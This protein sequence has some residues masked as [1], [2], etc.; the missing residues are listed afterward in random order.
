MTQKLATKCPHCERS[1]KID[2]NKVGQVVRCPACRERFTVSSI[3]FSEQQGSASPSLAALETTDQASSDSTTSASNVIGS[4]EPT[5]GK[6][7]RFELKSALGQGAFGTVYRAYDPVL[8]RQL[9]LK[10]PKFATSEKKKIRR[11]IREA[12][13][14]ASLHHPNIVAVFESGQANGQ[15]YIAS[16]FVDGTPMSAIIADERPDFRRSAEWILALAEGLAYAHEF[17]I[18]H[19]DI[20]PD[21]IMVGKSGHPQLMDF[22]LAKR[23]DE[24]SSMTAD[25]GVVGTP[26]YMPPEQ[27]RGDLES[28]GPHS[29]QYSLGVVLYE[30]L[31]GQRPFSGPPHSVI[32]QITTEN[33]PEPRQLD[34]E[35]PVDLAA[36]CSKAMEKNPEQRYTDMTGMAQDLERWLTGLETTARPIGRLEKTRRW[37]HR[38]RPFAASLAAVVVLLVVWLLGATGA[39]V[40]FRQ[41]EKYQSQLASENLELADKN[42]QLADES[43]AALVDAERARNN[44]EKRL[45]EQ[46]VSRGRGLCE[47]GDQGLGLH[48]LARALASVPAGERDMELAIR[49]DLGAFS[50]SI[51]RLTRMIPLGNE[52]TSVDISQ[53]GK[54]IAAV[55]GGYHMYEGQGKLFLIDAATGEV[56]GP[57]QELGGAGW[58]VSF[59]SDEDIVVVGTSTF[60]E[61][62]VSL[63]NRKTN[64]FEQQKLQLRSM[65]EGIDVHPTRRL[66]AVTTLNW[67]FQIWDWSTGKKIAAKVKKPP[68]NGVAFSPDGDYLA[69]SSLGDEGSIGRIA[70]WDVNRQQFSNLQI[71]TSPGAKAL[72]YSADGAFLMATTTNRG[73]AVFDVNSQY[74]DVDYFPLNVNPMDLSTDR[75]GE[76]TAISGRDGT[77][78]I[79]D[80]DSEELVGQSLHH[81]GQVHAVCFSPTGEQL[82]TAAEDGYVRIWETARRPPPPQSR[83]PGGGVYR[84]S[85]SPNDEI[86]LA[87]AK[88]NVTNVLSA[89]TLNVQNTLMKSRG[90]LCVKAVSDQY[91]ISDSLDKGIVELWDLKGGY[92]IS[93]ELKLELTVSSLDCAPNGCHIAIGTGQTDLSAGEIV[94]WDVQ[95]ASQVH[96]PLQLESPPLSVCY[97]PSGNLIAAGTTGG[98]V[99]C[100]DAETGEQLYEPIRHQGWVDEVDFTIDGALL[101]TGC[102]DGIV[103]LIDVSTGELT[104]KPLDIGAKINALRCAPDGRTIAVGTA[105]G[106]VRL[107]DIATRRQIGRTV[108][109]AS[110]VVTIDFTGQDNR[111]VTGRSNGIVRTWPLPNYDQRSTDSLLPE[112]EAATGIR[113]SSSGEREFL[114][115]T[116][117]DTI[118]EA[119]SQRPDETR[120]SV[121]IWLPEERNVIDEQLARRLEQSKRWQSTL[122]AVAED[123]LI[124]QANKQT[125]ALESKAANLLQKEDF[126]QA[127]QVFEELAKFPGYTP[128]AAVLYPLY[129]RT[130]QWE[131]ALNTG[132]KRP[133]GLHP[134]ERAFLLYELGQFDEYREVRKQLLATTDQ[135]AH[136]WSNAGYLY[137]ALLM[138]V[139]PELHP[140]IR[141]LAE[142]CATRPERWEKMMVGKAMYRLGEFANWHKNLP[143]DSPL[144]VGQEL[145]L[146]L[147]R[148]K[149]SPTEENRKSLQQDIGRLRDS[150]NRQI[151]DGVL[152]KYWWNY[153]ELMGWVR[154]GERVLESSNVNSDVNETCN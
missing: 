70:L 84:L 76:L 23:L 79:W 7:G 44:A 120:S 105:S 115:S 93:P 9:A 12:K 141:H 151:T 64:E 101:A 39:M 8:D 67:D 107:W 108:R 99:Y 17:N 46:Y 35:I 54:T 2:D 140:A 57:P 95:N 142:R 69:V 52:V 81:K 111:I 133:N 122:A 59:C 91:G 68:M 56:A 118:R 43:Q 104:G 123:S 77:A 40:Y 154:E 146:K 6:I 96:P 110:E 74:A 31:T 75:T 1:L 3:Q 61:G 143:D 113:L 66:L 37:A 117:W 121:E 149:N 30:L 106:L 86:I 85:V 21:N 138:P 150:A 88:S 15:I 134:R 25:G 28:V 112:I 22:G 55:T 119:V 29:D 33:P 131:K 83:V 20:K 116:V 127:I 36:I 137:A 32:A 97:S 63:F 16:G 72:C 98:M 48:W 103:R 130:M 65:I 128:D 80:A 136:D 78:H 10:V 125:A 135:L 14:A 109:R 87:A 11:F 144:K 38:N 71:T 18:I 19:R 50:Q 60:K 148:F 100:F 114:S 132:I 58:Y 147:T 89:E 62:S 124:A 152:D 153:I 145:R 51:H 34:S 47:S 42:A 45:V 24:D 129:A 13:A 82:I 90:Y 92:K 26:A 27:A 73:I 94:I 126:K 102:F 4:Q 41:Q 139:E 5:I 49:R 53:D